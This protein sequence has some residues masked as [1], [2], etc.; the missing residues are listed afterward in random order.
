MLVSKNEIQR[1]EKIQ[2]TGPYTGY[3]R[4]EMPCNPVLQ[5]KSRNTEPFLQIIFL[6]IDF[7]KNC[8]FYIFSQMSEA[9]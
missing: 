2:N 7:S 8:I 5:G 6:L 9:L 3:L 4:G 1:Q